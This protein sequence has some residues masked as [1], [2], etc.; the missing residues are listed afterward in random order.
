MN[1]LSVVGFTNLGYLVHSRRF[2]P[3]KSNMGGKV[4]VV[5][6][7]TAG[8]GLE[9]VRSLAALDARVYM[10]GRNQSKLDALTGSVDGDVVGVRADLSLLRDVRD[11]AE[12][13]LGSESRIDVLINNV[14]VLYRRRT[15]TAENIEASLATNLA[16][17]FL[18]TNLLIPRLVESAPARII[19][20][21]S[22]GMYSER[23]QPADLQFEKQPYSGATAYA[24]T[25]RGQII[26]TEM[27]AD[28]LRSLGVDVNATHPGWARTA[29]VAD[30]LPVFNRV[31]QPLLRTPQ[32][33]ADTMV[34]LA[35]EEDLAG[36]S[37]GLWFDRVTVPTHLVEKTRESAQDRSELWDRL[38]DLTDSDVPTI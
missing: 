9:T 6:G 8:L 7:A 16:G 25:K 12:G 28:R 13:L 33:G 20:V 14:G 18:L 15:V 37:G 11:L 35:S 19:N 23:I 36:S 38:V 32:Q 3:P 30:S 24:R 22:G 31:M 17:H 34:W 2:D 26:L 4:V 10:V 5:T 21:T 29:G 1:F 27:W